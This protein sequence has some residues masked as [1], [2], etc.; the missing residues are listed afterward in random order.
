MGGVTI[1]Q[2][3]PAQQKLLQKVFSTIQIQFF[4]VK[5]VLVQAITHQKKSFTT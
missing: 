3:N 5:K 2:K 4:H 1:T